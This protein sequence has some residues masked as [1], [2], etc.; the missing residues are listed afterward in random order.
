MS[1]ALFMQVAAERTDAIRQSAYE[2]CHNVDTAVPDNSCAQHEQC[3]SGRICAN[4]DFFSPYNFRRIDSLGV[5]E[6]H[7]NVQRVCATDACHYGR[8]FVWLSNRRS[9]ISREGVHS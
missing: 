5:C 6:R 9:P 2:W 3:S 8:G 7:P 4:C 1:I